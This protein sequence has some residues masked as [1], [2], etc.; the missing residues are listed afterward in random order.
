MP[1]FSS[2]PTYN[3]TSL[4]PSQSIFHCSNPSHNLFSPSLSLSLLPMMILASFTE[5]IYLCLAIS[6]VVVLYV[7]LLALDSSWSNQGVFL[8]QRDCS[9]TLLTQSTLTLVDNLEEEGLNLGRKL[10]KL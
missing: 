6:M 1:H 9:F 2:F 10:M 8:L 7:F 4:H 3:I 5:Q